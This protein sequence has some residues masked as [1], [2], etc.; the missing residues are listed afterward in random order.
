MKNGYSNL[1]VK[2][3]WTGTEATSRCVEFAEPGINPMRGVGDD[4]M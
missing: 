1:D 4:G 2:R 3:I